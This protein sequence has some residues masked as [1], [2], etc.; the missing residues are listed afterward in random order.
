MFV[1]PKK[2]LGQHFLTDKN[3]ALK[4]VNT[5][6]ATPMPRK[7]LEIGPGTG[8]LTQYLVGREDCDLHLIEIDR[9]SVAYLRA[10]YQPIDFVLIEA[11]F[12]ELDL[13]PF[14]ERFDIIGNFPYNISSQIFFRVLH[15]REQVQELVGMIQ[16]EVALRIAS[17]EGSRQY[18]I[19]SVLLQTFYDIEYCFKVP[20]QVFNPPPKVDSAVIRLR[21]NERKTL[22]FS[23]KFFITFVKTAFNQ[24]RKTLRNALKPLG[25]MPEEAEK[26]AS[27][28]AEQLSIEAFIEMA[29]M[30]ANRE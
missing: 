29:T 13:Q 27:K 20:P 14:G 11:D 21:R 26:Y 6:S 9:D 23:D 4:I 15:A 8:V 3:I 17:K 19:L 7:V 12:L 22:P 18:G 1:R 16:H 2:S 24:R 25:I 5:L 30:F 28:R 10:H